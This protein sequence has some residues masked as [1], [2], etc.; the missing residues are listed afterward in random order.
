[1]KRGPKPRCPFCGSRRTVRKGYRHTRTL[2]LRRRAICRACGRKFTVGRPPVLR[3]A[4]CKPSLPSGDER[5][6]PVRWS[7]VM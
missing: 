5:S 6:Q 7:D 2:G 1:M 4:P 3:V